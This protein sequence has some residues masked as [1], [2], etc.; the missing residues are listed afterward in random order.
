VRDLAF[1]TRLAFAASADLADEYLT[2]MRQMSWDDAAELEALG[3]PRRA[4]GTVAPAPTRIMLNKAGDRF[5]PDPAGD[6]AW[7][8]PVCVADLE[9]SD[10][11]ESKDPLRTAAR[12]TVIDLVAF[13]P[14]RRHR[15]ALRAGVATVLG[16]IEPQCLWPE[17]IRVH[18]DIVGWLQAECD[19]VVIL[20]KDPNE[21]R[22][23]LLQFQNIVGEDRRH[24]ELLRQV[25][26]TSLRL[27]A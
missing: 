18:R 23:V 8:F 24:T 6:D 9:R 7:C 19:G 5:C 3:I 11:V 2:Y 12:G 13:H 22:R 21:A 20:T 4:I 25:R 27:A 1:E 26:A 10:E 15:W 16:A 14:C 17:P